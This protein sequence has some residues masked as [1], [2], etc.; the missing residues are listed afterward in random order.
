MNYVK[1]FEINGVATKQA[2]CIELYGAPTAATEGI[3]GVLG[4]DVISPSHEIYKCVAVNGSVYTWKLFG[5]IPPV[6]DGVDG[7]SILCAL[8]TRSGAATTSFPFYQLSLSGG[9]TVK[10]G[11]LI[12]D[13]ETYLYQVTSVESDACTA[14]YLGVRLSIPPERG[15]DYWTEEDKREI[16]EESSPVRGTDYWTPEDQENIV[17]EALD[18]L[19]DVKPDLLQFAGKY[20]Q[21]LGGTIIQPL[22]MV[23]GSY[24]GTG[25][26][27]SDSPTILTSPVKPELVIIVGKDS[28]AISS[29]PAFGIITPDFGITFRR[30]GGYT[31][32]SYAWTVEGYGIEAV[33]V[34]GDDDSGY[35]ISWYAG[36]SLDQMTS[37]RTTYYYCIFGSGTNVTMEGWKGGSY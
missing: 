10:T 28:L 13:P 14:K 31:S 5:E 34:T 35:S 33:S 16:I 11:D 30:I 19:P 25:S 12:V 7:A 15:V 37:S 27:G 9:Y 32:G 29:Q 24:E 23:R 18:A 2:A 4:I 26:S 20:L 22:Q 36:G 17:L 1:Q 3:V 21:T 8:E 6:K